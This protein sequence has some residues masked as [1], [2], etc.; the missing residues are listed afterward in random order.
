MVYITYIFIIIRDY[1]EL[2]CPLWVYEQSIGALCPFKSKSSPDWHGSVGWASVRSLTKGHRQKVTG[3]IPGK[4]TC[5]GCG[6]G[7]PWSEHVQEAT[8]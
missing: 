8:N 7:C 1:I 2:S 4:G 5:L 6:F 3:S